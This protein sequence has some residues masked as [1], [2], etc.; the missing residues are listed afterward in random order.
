VSL[1]PL[2]LLLVR[3]S[4]VAAFEAAGTDEAPQPLA[5]SDDAPL[6]GTEPRVGVSLSD[7]DA[8]AHAAFRLQVP[9]LLYRPTRFAAS[10]AAAAAPAAPVSKRSAS[11]QATAELER[12]DAA[13]TR[14]PAVVAMRD[15]WQPAA[16]VDLD[17][18]RC[19]LSVV[20]VGALVELRRVRLSHNRLTHVRGMGLERL[21]KLRRIELDNNALVKDTV[22]VFALVPCLAHLTLFANPPLGA[23]YRLAVIAQTAC[24]AGDNR[25]PGLV[26]LD[27]RAVSID[28]RVAAAE[29]APR[30]R[31]HD[32]S[33]DQLRWRLA[34]IKSF[35]HAQLRDAAFTERIRVCAFRAHKLRAVGGLAMFSGLVVLDLKNNDVV[36]VPGLDRLLGLRLLNLADCAKLRLAGVLEQLRT[37][38]SLDQ[39][40]F[41]V[42]PAAR[43]APR[44]APTSPR[45]AEYLAGVVAALFDHERLR[46]VD[47]KPVP[48]A[49][50]VDAYAARPGVSTQ[51]AEAYRWALA[52]NVSCT[53]GF[54]RTH[55]PHAVGIGANYDPASITALRRTSGHSLRSGVVDL[56]AFVALEQLAL[57]A[58]LLT[59][60]AGLGLE[61][62]SRLQ[63]L[64]LHDNAIRQPLG[65]VAL[66]L[67]RLPQLETVTLR[68]NPCMSKS[69]AR[70]R[71][72]GA[73]TSLRR[74]SAR[75]RVLDTP[76]TVAERCDAWQAYGGGSGGD[77]AALREPA[78]F[79]LRLPSGVEH[80]DITSL[81]LSDAKLD[82]LDLRAFTS[83]VH[84]NL[85]GNAFATLAR[86]VG[87]L[88]LAELRTLNLQRNQ[89]ASVDEIVRLLGTLMLFNVGL[90]GNPLAATKNWRMRIIAG[91]PGLTNNGCLLRAIDDE[92]ITP[93]EVCAANAR[94]V[95]RE[96]PDAFRFRIA[97][98]RQVPLGVRLDDVVELDLSHCDLKFKFADFSPLRSILRLSMA[99]N[100]IQTKHLNVCGVVRL[101]TL[102][103]L[104]LSFNELTQIEQLGAL[105]ER[106]PA[107]AELSFQSNPCHPTAGID[108]GRVAV[109]LAR[110]PRVASVAAKLTHINGT[111]VSTQL[112]VGVASKILGARVG[113]QLAADFAV[114]EL[115]SNASV[116]DLSGRG[117]CVMSSL[118]SV[119]LR[120]TVLIL[121]RNAL[122]LLPA[123]LLEPL[124][125][126]RKLDLRQ[127]LLK[128]DNI[129]DVLRGSRSLQSLYLLEATA[130]RRQTG[131]VESF[132]PRF[133]RDFP[134]LAHCDGFSN[135][136]P[137]RQAPAKSSDD[138]T[139]RSSASVSVRVEPDAAAAEEGWSDRYML[140][141]SARIAA[142]IDFDKL[143]GG[144]SSGVS[145]VSARELSRAVYGDGDFQPSFNASAPPALDDDD[146]NNDN[147]DDVDVVQVERSASASPDLSKVPLFDYGK[148]DED[149]EDDDEQNG[150]DD[151]SETPPP[152]VEEEDAEQQEYL[153][154]ARR[155]IYGLPAGE[156]E[157]LSPRAS[158]SMVVEAETSEVVEVAPPAQYGRLPKFEE[159]SLA[160]PALPSA[161]FRR[162]SVMSLEGALPPLP[163][164][165]PEPAA[166]PEPEP[167]PEP[168]VD[169]PDGVVWVDDDDDDNNTS[170]FEGNSAVYLPA[171]RL[172]GSSSSS[173]SLELIDFGE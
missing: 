106:L 140:R 45:Y 159:L 145:G 46:F 17:L 131:V 136:K 4:S 148:E 12:F 75:L 111:P 139:V 114:A 161:P 76:I 37:T 122:V 39:V 64:E 59:T 115:P 92:R 153:S 173:S 172:S 16:L 71:L 55:H 100:R 142:P 82:V 62:L 108:A 58:N 29:L 144:E 104:D 91:L 2:P 99:H 137:V 19:Q 86:I 101:L 154:H 73:L 15:T 118:A 168:T 3:D 98:A 149:D 163:V 135:P 22:R 40:G 78:L 13:L 36:D 158:D 133:V 162:V 127:N 166:E 119:A 7:G 44:R 53:L 66:L 26:T 105:L 49:M 43:A 42:T 61:R 14:I 67:D 10:S 165:E 51:M 110:A 30:A 50:R 156:D 123:N 20:H 84:L 56:S 28:E 68:G 25:A 89:L 21:D 95:G 112:R 124:H 134:Q 54:N 41:A 31:G 146:D 85:A 32:L 77:V 6:F 74:P 141:Y 129:V 155:S 171:L 117:L 83:A 70:A 130:D 120:L 128:L 24:L 81:D 60:T 88:D 57:S 80:R 170:F 52:L 169:V 116:V 164:P 35:G 132:A 5:I 65:E 167:E 79:A 143:Y 47:G 147:D 87:L 18:R 107:L 9:C 63:R 97:M 93:A 94:M 157:L 1:A 96:E 102:E 23:D 109:M 126:L 11:K 160:L 8:A 90:E 121:A 69:D 34:L 113:E 103:R 72:L 48:A 152:P 38:R 33:P 125:A 151:S 150:D 27:N 138:A